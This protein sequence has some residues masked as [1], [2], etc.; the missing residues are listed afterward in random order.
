MH[1][2]EGTKSSTTPWAIRYTA[3][4]FSWGKRLKVPSGASAAEQR[5]AVTVWVVAFVVQAPWGF[6]GLIHGPGDGV[7]FTGR[8]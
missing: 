8:G 2:L 4:C 3:A 5:A 6:V 1:E 7:W